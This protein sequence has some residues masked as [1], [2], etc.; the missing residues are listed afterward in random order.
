MT[1]LMLSEVPAN[2][3]HRL[4]IPKAASSASFT[5]RKII[6]LPTNVYR[7]ALRS[8]ITLCGWIN[9]DV[10][11]NFCSFSF[12]SEKQ[13]LTSVTNRAD[14]STRRCRMVGCRKVC[15]KH[16]FHW[17]NCSSEKLSPMINCREK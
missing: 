1:V 4:L 13:F 12:V 8:V 3:V 5:S 7:I 17:L 14:H 2:K 9:Y 10:T 11:P 6:F 15:N 16:Q